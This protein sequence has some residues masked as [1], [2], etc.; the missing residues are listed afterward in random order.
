M[1]QLHPAGALD[2]AA[3]G[4]KGARMDWKWMGATAL[5]VLSAGCGS[6]EPAN[7]RTERTRQPEAVEGMVWIPGGTFM[8]G[9]YSGMPNEQPVHPV[10]LDGFYLDAHEVTNAEFREF[11]EATGYV[12]VA[13]RAMTE[14]QLAMVPEDQRTGEPMAFGAVVFR[15]TDGPVPLDSMAWWQM[16]FTA[17]WRQPDGEGS[18]IEGKNDHPVVCVTPEDAMAYAKWAGKRLPSEAEW[19]YAARGGLAGKKYEWGNTPLPAERD[20]APGD[21]PANL[22]QGKFP[23]EDWATDGHAGTAPVGS[24]AANGYGLYDMTG[25][26]WEICADWY[27][28]NYYASS[29]E[30]NP[31]GPASTQGSRMGAVSR[32]MRGASWRIHRSYGPAPQQGGAPIL[33]FRVATRNEAAT[34]TATNDVGFRCAMDPPMSE[35]GK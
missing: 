30:E 27:G 15:G 35:G 28:A 12:T 5:A 18:S 25:N 33:E 3:F 2:K 10:S 20:S 7:E 19:E 13:E 31:R 4:G 16:D 6:E 29:P 14:E 32:V 22:W 1:T 9:S 24:Y 34:D 17:N 21:W 26:V 11:V 23:Y 8:M